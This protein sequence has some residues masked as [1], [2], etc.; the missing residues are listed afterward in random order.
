M[1]K[2]GPSFL[3]I[4]AEVGIASALAART[5]AVRSFAIELD[6]LKKGVLCT[7]LALVLKK[8]Y[9]A[10]DLLDNIQQ[11]DSSLSGPPP[12][13]L[14][15]FISSFVARFDPDVISVSNT[16]AESLLPILGGLAS[17]RCVVVETI[18]GQSGENYFPP[19]MWNI[20]FL[21][22]GRG[23]A[24]LRR[25]ILVAIRNSRPSVRQSPIFECVNC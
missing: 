8:G 15:Q 2:D 12:A 16:C 14:Q 7:N 18:P 3:D 6:P 4:G 9:V 23:R 22:V 1:L 17:I 21:T 11:P 19:N 20:E 5:P 10:L 13:A 25:S 24:F